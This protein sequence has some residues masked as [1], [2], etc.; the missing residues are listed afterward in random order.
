MPESEVGMLIPVSLQTG[1]WLLK[2]GLKLILSFTG[3]HG[4][5]NFKP[6]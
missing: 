2:T 4:N 6:S 1:F 5:L 3:F